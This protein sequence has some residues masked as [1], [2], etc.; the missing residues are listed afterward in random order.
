[1]AGTLDRVVTYVAT[2]LMLATACT[3]DEVSENAWLRGAYRVGQGDAMTSGRSVPCRSFTKVHAVSELT[4]W[5]SRKPQ[6]NYR[7]C[8]GGRGRGLVR[9]RLP[10]EVNPRVRLLVEAE[11]LQG[12]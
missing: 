11:D 4:L 8:E 2:Q 9:L 5:V 6:R 3:A 10:G 7:G 12:G 1:M